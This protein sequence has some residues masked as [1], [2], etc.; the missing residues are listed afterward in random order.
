LKTKHADAAVDVYAYGLI[1]WALASR[2]EPWTEMNGDLDQIANALEKS[3]RP[4]ILEMKNASKA[5]EKLVSE[6]WDQTPHKRP[7]FVYTNEDES[8]VFQE[9]EEVKPVVVKEKRKS[10]IHNFPIFGSE[11]GNWPRSPLDSSSRQPSPG[12]H[13]FGDYAIVGPSKSS[14]SRANMPFQ[15]RAMPYT[16]F[17]R[18]CYL[19]P[20]SASSADG[21][22]LS[23]SEF[24][25]K[26]IAK[27]NRNRLE[28]QMFQNQLACGCDDH[29]EPAGYVPKSSKIP[30]KQTLHFYSRPDYVSPFDDYYGDSIHIGY[31][32]VWLWWS[33]C[34]TPC[35][36]YRRR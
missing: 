8:K 14:P 10:L 22:A 32:S 21:L 17:G 2:K 36:P 1:L 27:E 30:A 35:S 4:K 9:P 3:D 11:D 31:T 12:D 7:T 20:T 25:K 24:E 15:A 28:E 13:A 19:G 6:C 29:D 34:A 26:R 5:Y 16:A 33:L 23:I 18:P